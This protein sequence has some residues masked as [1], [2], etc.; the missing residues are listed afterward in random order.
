MAADSDGDLI[1]M[2]YVTESTLP[3]KQST[4]VLGSEIPAKH[5][6]GLA[7]YGGATLGKQILDIAQAQRESTVQPIGLADDLRWHAVASTKRPRR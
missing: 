4:S 1:H 6:N 5:A 7:G 2:P 3:T